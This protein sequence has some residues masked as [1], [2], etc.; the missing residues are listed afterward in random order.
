MNETPVSNIDDLA[1]KVGNT[2]ATGGM[3]SALTNAVYI[4]TF[5]NVNIDLSLNA[6]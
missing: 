3:T 5:V 6:K 1:S 2:H 4:V